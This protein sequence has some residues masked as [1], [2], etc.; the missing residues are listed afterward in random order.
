MVEGL[1]KEF[2]AK[3]NDLKKELQ[4]KISKVNISRG[5]FSMIE[6]YLI[7]IG[8]KTYP[9]KQLA[10]IV[11][12]DSYSIK[13]EP[14]LQD[15]VLFI[16]NALSKSNLNFT[17]TKEKDHLHLKFS[18]LTEETRKK[19]LKILSEEKERIKIESRKVRDNFLKKL[20]NAKE[21]KKIS[22][23]QF[24]RGKEKLDKL[25]DDFNKEVDK[26]YLQKE[27]EI[28]L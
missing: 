3:L 21:E 22:D 13:I 7:K 28:L 24:F 11:I 19:F 20:K 15:Y 10:N 2:E 25:I 26:V 12:L 5:G 17:L 1:I 23:D 14:Y 16:E 8:E 6:N 18:P 9:L 27:K 4:E